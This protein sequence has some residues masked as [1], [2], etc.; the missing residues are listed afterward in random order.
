M[1]LFDQPIV[2]P[3]AVA[4]A[5]S[6]SGM[7]LSASVVVALVLGAPD[8]GAPVS[9]LAWAVLLTQ[10][11]GAG[12]LAVGG[13][14]LAMGHSRSIVVAG[15]AVQAAVCVAYLLYAVLAVERADTAVWFGSTAVAF[16]ALAGAC[17]YLAVRN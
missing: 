14:R 6:A 9:I 1:S 4:L 8:P 10:V 15:A 2:R 7:T 5:V 11:T 3:A 13:V 17:A 16:A 12:L